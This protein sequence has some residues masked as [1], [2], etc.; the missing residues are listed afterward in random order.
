MASCNMEY[1][2]KDAATLEFKVALPANGKKE[3]VMHYHRRNIR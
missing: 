1:T 3:L 2:R